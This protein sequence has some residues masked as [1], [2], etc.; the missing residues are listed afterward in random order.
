M[1]LVSDKTS[2]KFLYKFLI[3]F[4]ERQ[5]EK[6]VNKKNTNTYSQSASF[7]DNQNQTQASSYMQFN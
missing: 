3:Y 6:R 5:E 1:S 4:K 7:Y 2:Y